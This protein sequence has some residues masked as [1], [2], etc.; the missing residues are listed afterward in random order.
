MAKE[1]GV[2]DYLRMIPVLSRKEVLEEY[3]EAAV[4]LSLPQDSHYAVPSKVYEYMRQP[5][6]ILAQATPDSATGELLQDS[7]AFLADQEDPSGMAG[8]LT[9]CYQEFRAGKRPSP[10]AV[11]TRFSRESQ[12]AVL[13]KELESLV[14]GS[15]ARN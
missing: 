9:R 11:D 2:L 10:I 14:N 4:L 6:W 7:S 12:G 1:E 5:C 15:L 8:F 13:M 3:A